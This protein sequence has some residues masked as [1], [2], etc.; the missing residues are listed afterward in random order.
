MYDCCQQIDLGIV[1]GLLIVFTVADTS[2]KK[3]MN[4]SSSFFLL[5]YLFLPFVCYLSTTGARFSIYMFEQK[6]LLRSIGS[7][8]LCDINLYMVCNGVPG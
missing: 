8:R 1:S 3:T 5:S 2:T 4:A 6:H 7:F